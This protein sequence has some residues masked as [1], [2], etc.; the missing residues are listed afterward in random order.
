MHSLQYVKLHIC[1]RVIEPE[2]LIEYWNQLSEN[3]KDNCYLRQYIPID[4]IVQ[5]W[6]TMNNLN[7]NLCVWRQ[8]L[9]PGFIA[10]IFHTLNH[11]QKIW[12][13]NHQIC[14]KE[15]SVENIVPLLTCVDPELREYGKRLYYKQRGL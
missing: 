2:E 12:C 9:T 10:S 8:K 13:M 7:R 5:D 4:I 1:S 14:L 3:H 15:V 6:D 11:K